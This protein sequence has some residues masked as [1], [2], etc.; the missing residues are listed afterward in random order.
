MNFSRV[1]AALAL[2]TALALSIS[3]CASNN[4]ETGNG[5]GNS[6]EGGGEAALSGT[7]SGGGASSQESAMNGWVDGF[8]SV[9]PDVEVLYD[10]VGSGNGRDGFTAGKYTF[11]G[12][13]AAMSQ[14]DGQKV[15]QCG[16]DGIINIPA[17]ISPVAVAYNLPDV[18][19]ENINMDAATIGAIFNG[20]IKKWNDPK[21]AEQNEGV[22]LPDMP[23]TLVV[24]GD[25]SGTT[26]NFTAYLEA[27]APDAW[28][29][30]EVE[31]WPK[32]IKAESAQQTGGVVGLAK[33]TP[34]AITYADASA[35]E[36]LGTVA[37]KV[38][39]EYVPYS[40]DAAS[41][42]VEKSKPAGEGNDLAVELDRNTQESGVYPIV[43][44]SYH[45]YCQKYADEKTA[46]LVKA[47][48]KYMVS[49]DGQKAAAESAGNAP[50][51]DSL[52][53]K[54]TQ[55]IDSIGVQ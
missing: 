41:A 4:P 42:A 38:G 54:A 25:S 34:G 7:L 22:E 48:G 19:A 21:I 3:A 39:E 24:R 18:D 10:V 20:S 6:G 29:H 35:T 17:Y 53:E 11:A 1:G 49:A 44:V 27:A 28:T 16:T 31:D 30:G 5:N 40:A 32:D 45:I 12:S 50:L 2:S 36:G 15:E 14:E 47:F 8:S 13:D 26:E 9:Q 43:L 55:A 51:S 33:Q 37:V 46:E 23:I 52:S